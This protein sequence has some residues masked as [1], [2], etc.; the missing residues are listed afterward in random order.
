M[1]SLHLNIKASTVALINACLL[2]STSTVGT[3]SVK[4]EDFIPLMSEVILKL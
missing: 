1:R 2:L 3:D 4:P